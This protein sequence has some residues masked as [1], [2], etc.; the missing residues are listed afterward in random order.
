MTADPSPVQAGIRLLL[1]ALNP[2]HSSA[3]LDQSLSMRALDFGKVRILL[4]ASGIPNGPSATE[5]A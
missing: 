1:L 2:A 4:Y 3:A 5:L